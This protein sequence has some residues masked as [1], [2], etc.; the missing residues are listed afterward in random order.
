M[1]SLERLHRRSPPPETVAVVV[2]NALPLVG[3]VAL[4][5]DL[6]ALVLLYWIELGV[7]SFWALV[8]ALFAGRPSEFEPDPL[9]AGALAG[10][11]VAIPV[12]F[13]EL[14]IRLSTLPVLAVAVPLLALVWFFAGV[15]TVGVVGPGTPGSDAAVT[16]A[17]ASAGILLGEGVSTLVDYFRRG[18]YREHSAQ[19]AIQGVFTRGAVVGIGGLLTATFV[20]LGAGSVSPDDPITAV[21]PGVVGLPILAGIVLVKFGFDLGGL[22]RDRLVALDEASYFDLGWAYEPPSEESVEPA[23]EV[24]A[25]LRPTPAG[26]LLGCL[27]GSNVRRHPGALGAGGLLLLVSAL[28]AIGRAWDV[29]LALVLAGLAVSTGLLAVDFWLRYGSVEYRTSG[30]AVVAY[31]RLFRTR[32]WRV[33]PWDE[34]GLRVER[35]RLHGWLDT[36]TVVVECPDRELRLP[37]LRDPEPILDVFDRRADGARPEAT[38]G[39]RRVDANEVR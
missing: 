34:T 39:V 26:R 32:V 22:Y 20:G 19:T 3:V 4:G 13:T 5:W 33:E 1:V 6:A 29:V 21:D 15:A 23:R 31:D 28:F 8:R 16:V 18:G 14:G 10:R 30:D 38:T 2:A 27:S 35:D 17:L 7:L 9:I 11:R 24:D 12:P 37:Q 25:R 36:A